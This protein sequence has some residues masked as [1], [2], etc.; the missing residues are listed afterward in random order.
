[1]AARDAEQAQTLTPDDRMFVAQHALDW[2]RRH[3]LDGGIDRAQDY[4]AWY[5]NE[6]K[7]ALTMADFP[8][9]TNAWRRFAAAGFPSRQGRR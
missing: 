7:D 8:A 2:G 1:M 4:A 9:H 6:H 3:A 5:L